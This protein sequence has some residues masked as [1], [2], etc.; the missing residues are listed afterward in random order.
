MSLLEGIAS[1][2]GRRRTIDQI[3]IDE[4]KRERIALEQAQNR[5]HRE[6]AAMEAR[7][8]ELFLKGKDATS[9]RQRLDFAQQVAEVDGAI[10]QKAKDLAL[11][12]KQMQIIA[13]LLQ[14]KERAALIQSLKVGSIISRL[15]V[16]ELAAYV[17]RAT[18]NERFEMEKFASLLEAVEGGAD[19]IL[20]AAAS[21]EVRAIAA[22]MEQA[23]A[24]E[25]A[26]RPE[27]AQAAAQ[28]LDE[29]LAKD[30]DH[31]DAEE[32]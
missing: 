19:E 7:K 12:R 3:T 8:H 22:A 1:L 9:S 24:A 5:V 18:I 29:V 31:T 25:E 13:G 20:E 10:R 30:H 23:R 2:F 6:I 26:G 4:L 11:V 17:D 27:E 14:I 28:K 16:E 32:S 15:S 21:P